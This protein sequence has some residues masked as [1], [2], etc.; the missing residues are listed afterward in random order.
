MVLKIGQKTSPILLRLGLSQTWQSDWY[1]PNYYSQLLHQD[2]L[3]RDYLNITYSNYVSALVSSISRPI[4]SVVPKGINKNKN[5]LS[6]A[7]LFEIKTIKENSFKI[8]NQL[9]GSYNLYKIRLNMKLVIFMMRRV[10]VIRKRINL[11]CLCEIFFEHQNSL[12]STIETPHRWFPK[13]IDKIILLLRA[14]YWIKYKCNINYIKYQKN[15]LYVKAKVFYTLRFIGSLVFSDV[16]RR[17]TSGAPLAWH[18]VKDFI[19]LRGQQS[20]ST[21]RAAQIKQPIFN[22]E[23]DPTIIKFLT[24]YT[25][26]YLLALVHLKWNKQYKYFIYNIIIKSISNPIYTEVDKLFLIDSLSK[27][28]GCMDALFS[29]FQGLKEPMKQRDSQGFGA[30]AWSQVVEWKQFFYLAWTPYLRPNSETKIGGVT[31]NLEDINSLNVPRLLNFVNTDSYM[32]EGRGFPLSGFSSWWWWCVDSRLYSFF[33]NLDGGPYKVSHVEESRTSPILKNEALN[34]CAFNGAPWLDIQGFFFQDKKRFNSNGKSLTVKKPT[35][36]QI[37]FQYSF[38]D[39]GHQMSS[40]SASYVSKETTLNGLFVLKKKTFQKGIQVHEFNEISRV[41]YEAEIDRRAP[42]RSVVTQETTVNANTIHITTN[43]NIRQT[44]D[45]GRSFECVEREISNEENIWIDAHCVYPIFFQLCLENIYIIRYISYD[46][47]LFRLL[48]P[49]LGSTFSFDQLQHFFIDF[50]FRPAQLLYELW[51]TSNVAWISF[52]NQKAPQIMDT[53]GILRCLKTIT[54]PN[55]YWLENAASVGISARLSLLS[56]VPGHGRLALL[57]QEVG[58]TS[59]EVIG[60]PMGTVIEKSPVVGGATM[61]PKASRCLIKKSTNRLF[62]QLDL[63]M[64]QFDFSSHRDLLN[65]QWRQKYQ[66]YQ[67]GFQK[68]P[69]FSEQTSEAASY[70]TRTSFVG[71]FTQKLWALKRFQLTKQPA[72]QYSFLRLDIIR[73]ECLS[74]YFCSFEVPFFRYGI[75]ISKEAPLKLNLALGRPE[76][77]VNPRNFGYGLLPKPKHSFLFDNTSFLFQ[78]SSFF[79]GWASPVGFSRGFST[80]KAMSA[81]GLIETPIGLITNVTGLSGAHQWPPL[82]GQFIIKHLYSKSHNASLLVQNMSRFLI[83]FLK[84]NKGSKNKFQQLKNISYKILSSLIKDQRSY[85]QLAV[86][87]SSGTHHPLRNFAPRLGIGFSFS[88]RVYGA[89]KATSHKMLF[90]SVPFNTLYANIDYA[91]LTQKT[92]N[93]TWGFQTWLHLSKKKTVNVIALVQFA[94]WAFCGVG[95]RLVR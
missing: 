48:P 80:Q 84:R 65:F 73:K 20:L 66:K 5:K 27:Y 52:S 34:L 16:A 47:L 76:N 89:T 53:L 70:Q 87:F 49:F 54:L 92:R 39:Y 30:R 17:A 88:G 41:N 19:E 12:N 60:A 14:V 25:W 57:G 18:R 95:A 58:S 32:F 75:D 61:Q 21:T 46:F 10:Y 31:K 11:I 55:F 38:G 79:Y 35:A 28:L 85:P 69:F 91:R 50:S 72:F 26:R 40:S 51:K 83:A 71:S 36:N 29:G 77:F 22:F 81:G 15:I 8:Y 67:W 64:P 59:S 37:L 24:L 4:K 63:H 43:A 78:P 94:Q 86:G 93:G 42:I 90:G 2:L 3:T 7:A 13:E 23:E 1:N 74:F 6:N 56:K 82:Y 9:M 44:Q 45:D 62:I 33:F 68:T